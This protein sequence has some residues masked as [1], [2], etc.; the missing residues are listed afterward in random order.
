MSATPSLAE[1]GNAERAVQLSGAWE[2]RMLLVLPGWTR[3]ERLAAL[4]SAGSDGWE[5]WCVGDRE[6]WLKR[7]VR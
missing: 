7:R 3:D 4:N 5:A 2:Y 1:E 6:I